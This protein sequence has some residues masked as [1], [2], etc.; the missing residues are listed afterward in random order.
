MSEVNYMWVALSHSCLKWANGLLW[1]GVRSAFLFSAFMLVS[2]VY[3]YAA[4]GARLRALLL[5]VKD[6]C[7]LQADGATSSIQTKDETAEG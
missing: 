3:A 4:D 6:E 2:H 7:Q 5:S 1:I